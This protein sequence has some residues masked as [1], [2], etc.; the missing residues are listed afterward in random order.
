MWTSLDFH[1]LLFLFVLFLIYLIPFKAKECRSGKS[2]FFTRDFPDLLLLSLLDLKLV[3]PLL[4]T[5]SF[6][7]IKNKKKLGL[8]FSAVFSVT[9]LI[10]A[11][12]VRYFVIIVVESF[13]LRRDLKIGNIKVKRLQ[14]TLRPRNTN[15]TGD[16]KT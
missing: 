14:G 15:K 7:S 1:N 11:I 13:S 8:L 16:S 4:L 3:K 2:R 10:F 12:Q 5:S 9:Y 6:V